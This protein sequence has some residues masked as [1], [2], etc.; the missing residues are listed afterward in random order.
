MGPWE[1]RAAFERLSSGARGSTRRWGSAAPGTRAEQWRPP[2]GTRARVARR[3]R[4]RDSQ[5][6]P[7]PRLAHASPAFASSP[8]RALPCRSPAGRASG[9]KGETREPRASDGALLPRR[10]RGSGLPAQPPARRPAGS[11]PPPPRP[12][13]SRAASLGEAAAGLPPRAGSSPA[14]FGGPGA[15]PAATPCSPRRSTSAVR[16]FPSPQTRANPI[17][18]W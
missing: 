1:W 12:T 13:R 2:R 14:R 6:R 10:S 4:R 7:P 17:L 9:W 16:A 15:P 8:L 18:F 11:P 5:G 3:R